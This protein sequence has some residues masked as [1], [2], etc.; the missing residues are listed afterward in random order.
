[1]KK[2]IILTFI[3]LTGMTVYGQTNVFPVDGNVGV[4]T[5]QPSSKVEIKISESGKGLQ[6]VGENKNVDL[7]IGHNGSTHGY[8]WRYKGV[9]S[10]NNNDLELWT[11]NQSGTDLQ[12]YN[13]HQDG[14]IQF[15]RSVSIGC[16]AVSGYK[17]AVNGSIRATEIKVVAQT[18]DFVFEPDYKL[19]PL[20]EV[21]VFV[22]ENKHL[23]E[24]PSAKQ[25]EAEGVNVAEMNKLLLQKV[26]E[27]TLYTIA[28]KKKLSD[29][30]EE[31]DELKKRM[32]LLESIIL[33]N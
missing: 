33:K 7:H 13:I 5:T 11:N 10:A 24:I 21:E 2:L 9:D 29:K 28:Q 26:E 16:E 25:M 15:V 1:M 14:N 22:K 30:S 3:A 23:P 27:L 18:A 20:D 31:L 6:I 32:T 4:G 12:V 8:Y 19:R 17:L